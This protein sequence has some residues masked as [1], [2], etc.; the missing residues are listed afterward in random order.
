MGSADI[1]IDTLIG[2][3]PS[4]SS[5]NLSMRLE[6]D[7]RKRLQRYTLVTAPMRSLSMTASVPGPCRYGVMRSTALEPSTSVVADFVRAIC[8]AYTGF[9]AFE[10]VT[11]YRG[12]SLLCR[13]T[14]MLSQVLYLMVFQGLR[15]QIVVLTINFPAVN[16]PRHQ[17]NKCTI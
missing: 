6:M 3:L 10:K 4:S 5:P 1:I 11:A 13:I 15:M 12:Q 17:T 8:R 2:P 9:P 16:P 14:L 7:A